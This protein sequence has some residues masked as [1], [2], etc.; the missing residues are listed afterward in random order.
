VPVDALRERLA[1]DGALLE[2]VP[3]S[4]GEEVTR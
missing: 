1:L 4:T 2:P 3:V